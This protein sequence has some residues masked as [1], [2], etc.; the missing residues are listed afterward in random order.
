M[1]PL[2]ESR[3]FLSVADRGLEGPLRASSMAAIGDDDRGDA[4]SAEAAAAAPFSRDCDEAERDRDGEEGERN[5]LE[6]IVFNSFIRDLEEVNRI[7][8][9]LKKFLS[10]RQK[11][12]SISNDLTSW[13]QKK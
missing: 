4:L 11:E 8:F 12:Q 9:S 2:G 10:K 3:S 7:C 5:D 1:G 13:T 6:D